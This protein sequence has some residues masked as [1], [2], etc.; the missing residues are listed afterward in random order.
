L[1]PLLSHPAMFVVSPF[2]SFGNSFISDWLDF[3]WQY[4]NPFPSQQIIPNHWTSCA[5]VSI[6][7]PI[8]FQKFNADKDGGSWSEQLRGQKNWNRWSRKHGSW[9]VEPRRD[10]VPSDELSGIAI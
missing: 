3:P 10:G 7:S 6:R 1:N 9:A 2:S 4:I 5:T 8:S